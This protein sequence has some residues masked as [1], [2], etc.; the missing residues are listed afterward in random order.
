MIRAQRRK[1]GVSRAFIDWNSQGNA[2]VLE[3]RIAQD[4]KNVQRIWMIGSTLG[5]E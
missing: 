1:L 2:I 5:G 4:V 3:K